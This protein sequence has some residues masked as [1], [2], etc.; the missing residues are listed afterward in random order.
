MLHL[1]SAAACVLTD[2][3]GVQKEAYYLRVPCVT[4]RD[5]TEW[6]ETVDVGWNVL[7]GVNP[8][9]IVAAVSARCRDDHPHPELYGDGLTARRIVDVLS[10]NF[11]DSREFAVMHG[12]TD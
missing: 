2:S 10:A 1:Q 6:V 3:G 11:A 8:E 7:A 5:E 12:R 4:L 9:R